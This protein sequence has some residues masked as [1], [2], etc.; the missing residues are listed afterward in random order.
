MSRWEIQCIYSIEI[1]AETEEE[2]C[3]IGESLFHSDTHP[4]ISVEANYI[5]EVEE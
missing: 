3:E 5:G 2:A 1:E 4:S